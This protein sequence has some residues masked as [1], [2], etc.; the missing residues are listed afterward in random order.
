MKNSMLTLLIASSLI[1]SA[2]CARKNAGHG[3]KQTDVEGTSSGGGG[4]GDE[5]SMRL[6]GW[7]KKVV[8]NAIRQVNPQALQGLP[9]GW[10][11]E[12]LARLIDH[13]H[14]EPNRVVYRYGRELMFDYKIPK[15]GEPY[16]IA[17]SLY[18]RSHASVPLNS[19]MAPQ[20]EP[21][22]REIRTKLL[23]EMAHVLGIGL[24]EDTDHKARGFAVHL[25]TNILSKNNVACFTK[26]VPE[27]YQGRVPDETVE[28]EVRAELKNSP[29]DILEQRIAEAK[30]RPYYWIVNRPFGFGL[31]V[32]REPE[33]GRMGLE[34]QPWMASLLD[35]NT[36]ATYMSLGLYPQQRKDPSLSNGIPELKREFTWGIDRKSDRVVQQYYKEIKIQ[37][38]KVNVKGTLSYGIEGRDCEVSETISFPVTKDHKFKGRV[39]YLNSCPD[40][41]EVNSEGGPKRDKIEADFGV[42][43]VEAWNSLG[44][45]S[46]FYGDEPF[47]DPF[48]IEYDK[49]RDDLD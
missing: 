25:I 13:V 20:R 34:D 16:L 45:I 43:C 24:T 9:Q 49:T 27:S 17:T 15:N 33:S 11:Q 31:Q 35:G 42:D 18:F 2:G 39:H 3:D 10:T 46:Q 8:S 44:D 29:Q 12:R 41:F 30:A 5:N 14:A 32:R 22:I 6:L 1:L 7:A 38:R 21:Y 48:L 40:V 36:R 19:L 37:N 28:A 26:E 47:T 23:H 4:F